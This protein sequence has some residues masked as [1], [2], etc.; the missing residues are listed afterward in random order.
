[1]LG[2]PSLRDVASLGPLFPHMDSFCKESCAY[3][4]IV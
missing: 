3:I 1:M 2:T 4:L